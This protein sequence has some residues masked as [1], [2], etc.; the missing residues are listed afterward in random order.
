MPKLQKPKG[1]KPGV[2]RWKVK[3]L[4]DPGAK[5]I[6]F[7][8]IDTLTLSVVASWKNP[9]VTQSSTNLPRGAGPQEFKVYRLSGQARWFKLEVDGDYHLLVEDG[10]GRSINIEF[11][12]PPFA[13]ASVKV[14]EIAKTRNDFEKVIGKSRTP[15][16]NYKPVNVPVIIT[17]VG[18]WDEPHGQGGI[19][20]G[21][22]L[23]PALSI[24]RR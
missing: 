9:G 10:K 19:G 22:E 1:I 7:P 3:T 5:N 6:D 12:Y 14:M 15:T 18:F 23:H 17:G 8:T 4:Q 13:G 16:I 2:F 11:P 24:R 21:F 20:N